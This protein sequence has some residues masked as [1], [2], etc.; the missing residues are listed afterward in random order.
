M[1]INAAN[2]VE[3]I[4]E[5]DL[6]LSQLLKP[7]EFCD[8][9]QYADKLAKEFKK[10]LNPT[11]LRKFF[12]SIKAIEIKLKNKEDKDPLPTT[13]ARKIITLIPELAYAKGRN[14]I[15]QRFYELMSAC[16]SP[17]RLKTVGDLKCLDL[18]L[19][20]FLAYHKYYKEGGR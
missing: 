7:E 15:P 3:K 5:S 17:K 2:I 6:S 4:K 14:L 9:G 13:H 10:S 8:R 12:S 16:L 18:F 11:Q 19:T 1:S 20:T